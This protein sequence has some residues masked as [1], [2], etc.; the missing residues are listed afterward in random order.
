MSLRQTIFVAAVVALPAGMPASAAQPAQDPIPAVPLAGDPA[1]A[2]AAS[3]GHS[4]LKA[5]TFKIGSTVSNLALLSY[6][7]GDFVGGTALAGFMLGASWVIYT[8]NDYLWDTYSPPPAKETASQEFD[9]SAD[10]WR[11]TGKFLTYKPIV[12]SLKLASLYY[13]T[14]SAATAAVFGTASILTNT[15]V[16][17]ANNMAWDLRDWYANQP[18]APA[19]P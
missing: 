2:N 11:N 5:T 4:A 17:Y 19:K 14:G 8:A 9:A 16:F 3:L 10:V 6:A 7:T 18:V 13:Y 1:P 12:A 15:V